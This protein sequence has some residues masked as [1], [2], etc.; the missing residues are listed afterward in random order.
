MKTYLCEKPSQGEDVAKFLGMTAVHKKRG[1]YQKGDVAVT[2]ARGHLF[3]LKP[4]EHYAPELG[5]KWDLAHL[6]VVPEKYEYALDEKA[7]AQFK[8]I[9]ERLSKTTELF[10]ATDPDP[11]GEC[12]ARNIIRFCGYKGELKRVLYSATDK[13]TLKKAFEKPLPASETEW[14]F[15]VALARAQSD[16]VV[17]MNLTMAMTLVVQKVESS[18]A[19]KKK[20]AFS[21]GR[22]KTPTAMLVYLREQAIREFKPT[23]YFGVEV[24]VFTEE[25]EVFKLAWDIPGK[26]LKDGKLLDRSFAEKVVSYMM[27]QKL[28]IV[29]SLEEERKSVEPLLPYELTGLQSACER[30]ELGPDETLEIAQSLYDKPFSSTTYPRTSVGYIPEG[31]EDDIEETVSSL[32]MLDVFGHLEDKLDLKKRTKA[33][34]D[35]KVNVHHG[36]I[37]T[38]EKFDVSRMSQKQKMVFVL[39]AKRYLSQFMPDYE[40]DH[41]EA[42]VKIGNLECKVTSNVS[43]LPGWK[44]I[45]EV[46]TDKEESSIPKLVVGQ[47]V[48][49]SKVRLVEKTTRKPSRYTKA[50]LAKAME[51]VASEVSDPKLKKILSEKDGIGTVATRASTIKELISSGLLEEAKRQLKPSEWLEKFVRLIPN[52]MKEPG[53]TALW[54]KG[55]EAIEHGKITGE[56]FVKFQQKFVVVSVKELEKVYGEI[57]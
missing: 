1:Y 18:G 20:K 19:R 38:S 52:Q 39:I 48:G 5:K 10:I 46:K 57:K 45:E 36:I 56:Q 12:I 49:V 44:E 2:W 29:T 25:K 37:P 15:K 31:L 34:N 47:K 22:V 21:I 13:R 8:V 32:L 42:T 54:E 7:K 26:Y 4:P 41:T 14:M 55:F 3:K 28:G 16:W 9:K 11:E 6:P 35:K 23:K 27:E 24:E 17:G 40:Y 53:N 43:V 30:Y 33:W 50:S 51:N